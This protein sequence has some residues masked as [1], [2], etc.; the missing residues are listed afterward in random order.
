MILQD[1]KSDR[2]I[3]QVSE[4][5]GLNRLPVSSDG[6]LLTSMNMKFDLY[7]VLS[8]R[9]GRT[10]HRTV[11]GTPQGILFAKDTEYVVSGGTLYKDGEATAL[12][13]LSDGIKSMVE[14]WG[15]IFIFP[16]AKYYD[17]V[18]GNNGNI[19]TGVYPAEGS[20]PDMDF[21]CVHNNR[22]WGVKGNY[23]Y[24]S[25]SGYAMGEAGADGRFGWTQFYDA[26]G[27]P[28]DNGSFFQEVAGYGDFTGIVS[29]DDRIV[30]LKER[31]HHE[32]NG[33]YPSNFAL[34]TI[35][36]TGTIDNRSIAEVNSRLMYASRSGI[37]IYA[38]GVENECSRKL[39]ENIECAV[40]GT[41]GSRYYV[42][43][44]NGTEKKLYMYN[45]MTDMWTEETPLDVTAF[46]LYKGC[47]YALCADGKIV[48]MGD[49]AS[50]EKVIWSFSFSDYA[51]SVYA[52][53]SIRKLILKMKAPTGTPIRVSLSTDGK[54]FETL[55][56][57]TFTDETMQTVKFPLNRGREH[58]IRVEGEGDIEIYGYQLTVQKGG[59]NIV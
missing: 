51:D 36:K 3:R 2:Y 37:Y 59:E 9:G 57:Y 24:A 41:D 39:Y 14:F 17:T 21:V 10:V 23:I 42:C 20:C 26:A 29:W 32:I 47:V 27:N 35:S 38:G 43:I 53:S 34:S 25:S 8:V 48:K 31:C 46:S 45:A 58:I 7:P 54:S 1:K 44:D 18:T 15:K 49:T 6:E 19:G 16:D 22:I 55:K 11:M 13:G 40:A 50:T 30:A 28:D 52:N 4:F 56:E 5:K 33:S 12:N